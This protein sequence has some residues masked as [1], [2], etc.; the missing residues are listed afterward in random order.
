MSK[1]WAKFCFFQYFFL[2]DVVNMHLPNFY[3]TLY[4][5]LYIYLL[6][7][8]KLYEKAKIAIWIPRLLLKLLS[9]EIV[10]NFISWCSTL[11]LIYIMIYSQIASVG[12]F[13]FSFLKI[14]YWIPPTIYN[15]LQIRITSPVQ[16]LSHL[17]PLL[18]C[19]QWTIVDA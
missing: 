8:L 17:L 10:Q 12:V 4:K 11:Y 16:V 7:L 14:L 1:K 19:I 15:V 6:C 13:S 3:L 18:L 2:Y 5:C 9:D